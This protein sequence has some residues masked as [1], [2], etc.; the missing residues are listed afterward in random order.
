MTHIASAALEDRLDVEARGGIGDVLEEGL[1]VGGGRTGRPAEDILPAGV[2]LGQ[3]VT[4]RTV[5]VLV[6]M[7]GLGQIP[8]AGKDVR[9]WVEE[10]FAG[11]RTQ[12]FGHGP[13]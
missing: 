8:G 3:A 7:D 11:D 2:V 4:F 10:I 13:F 9:F 1:A 5:S 6:M 12:P